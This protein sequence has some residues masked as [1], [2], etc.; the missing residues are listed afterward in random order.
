[1][2]AGRGA[3]APNRQ[4]KVPSG[5]KDTTID[6]LEAG[7]EHTVRVTALNA[8]GSGQTA[9]QRGKGVSSEEATGTPS[10]R[11]V[12]GVT[13]TPV[14]EGLT[15]SWRLVPGKAAT[16][17]YKVQW[18]SGS[19]EFKD[20]ATDNR[21]AP[22]SGDPDLTGMSHTIG[23]PDA[24]A[25]DKLDADT[26][27]SVRVIATNRDASAAE[28][29]KSA[30]GEGK[31]SDP[32]EGTPLPGKVVVEPVTPGAKQLTVMWAAVKG[33]AR[34]YTVQWKSG[35]EEYHTNR[36]A[37]NVAGTRYVRRDLEAN[38]EYTIRVR[39][40]NAGHGPWSDDVTGTPDPVGQNQ[41]TNVVVTPGIKQLAVRWRGVTAATGY[42]VQWKK[43]TD[44]VSTYE[45]EDNQVQL[46]RTIRSHTIPKLTG[47][48]EYTVLVTAVVGETDGTPSD[49]AYGM[50]SLERVENVVVSAD[51]PDLLVVSW[52]PVTGNEGYLV[53][54]KSPTQV[55][56]ANQEEKTEEDDT[57]HQI[58][59]LEAGTEYT[60]R[61]RALHPSGDGPWSDDETGT[62][63]ANPNQVANVRVTEGALQL[64]VKWNAVLG[65]TRYRVEWN[66]DGSTSTFPN[67]EE[68]TGGSTTTFTID[69]DL[70]AGR[71]YTVR[72]IAVVNGVDQPP[73][74]VAT[75]TPTRT[76]TPRD[77]QPPRQP[78]P[79]PP[80]QPDPQPPRQPDPQPDPQPPRQPK[81]PAASTPSM[82][83][84]VKPEGG[85]DG[86]L[87]VRWFSLAKAGIR[88]P[89]TGYKV[90]W[91]SGSQSYASAR[92]DTAT[93]PLTWINHTISGSESRDRVHGAGA[94]FQRARR[95]PGF[96]GVDRHAQA[97]PAVQPDRGGPERGGVR[98]SAVTQQPRGDRVQRSSLGLDPDA[99]LDAGQ[100]VTLTV[101][102][103]QAASYVLEVSGG[104]GVTLSG[105]GVTDEGS[106]RARLDEASWSN[107]QRTVVLKDTAAVDTLS[108]RLLDAD[109]EQVAALEPKI[110]YNPEVR[111]GL[112]VD[113]PA[114][115]PGGEPP[116]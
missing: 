59:R 86:G 33:A 52:D 89:L 71:K 105:T 93:G 4:K 112:R 107:L 64:T 103:V 17:R 15:V 78:D 36:Q 21:E 24:D 114:G 100:E 30:G 83:K 43:A 87:Q 56:S 28:D 39:A 46:G 25:A 1:M 65:A 91:K 63:V 81:P 41:V 2:E 49:E 34:G 90:Q 60:V 19:Q 3:W 27:Y 22:G 88:V 108:V 12:T 29:E 110:V 67:N 102:V 51:A 77:P 99:H 38:T 85:T 20:A 75:G 98:G 23:G 47:G 104:R 96:A 82:V 6:G 10:P 62:P 5:T 73:S 40:S 109:G 97:G 95:R 111:H 44:P 16:T 18:R 13:V 7:N 50:P 11:Q 48:T 53:Q 113:R 76:S 72:V 8:G 45:L 92:E 37:P 79:Q 106:G 80:R 26:Q 32:E 116:V 69:E 94:G 68:V 74:E 84:H 66:D 61:V 31:A 115:H 54:W 101:S 57:N 9:E 58:L 35:N 42:R 70:S 14:S 55:Y